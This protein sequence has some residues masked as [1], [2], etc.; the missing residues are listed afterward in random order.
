[1]YAKI[2][3]CIGVFGGAAGMIFIRHSNVPALT[4]LFYRLLFTSLMITIPLVIIRR[5]DTINAFRKNYKSF[6]IL[7]LTALFNIGAMVCWI[8]AVKNTSIASASILSNMHPVLVLLASMLIF[9]IRYDKKAIAGVFITL[10]GC[11]AM[12]ARDYLA[13]GNHIT[14]DI[15]AILAGMSFGL[16]LLTAKGVR[17]KLSIDIFMFINYTLSFVYVAVLALLFREN[18][19]PVPANEILIFLCLAVFSTIFGQGLVD[20]GLAYVSS[21]F[22]SVSFLLEN[23]YA[24]ILGMIFAAEMPPISQLV[25]GAILVAG[26]LIFNKYEPAGP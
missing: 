4:M 6:R 22:A 17:G 15:F 25:W 7:F 19:F 1:V 5:K 10:V 13:D 12:S 14:G 2:V 9:K 21:S 24:I 20:W 16:Y 3:V 18:L 23:I 11:A 26:V 8:F